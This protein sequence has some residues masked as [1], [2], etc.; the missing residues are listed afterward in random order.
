MSRSLLFASFL[1]A[2][3]VPLDVAAQQQFP[4]TLAGH[5]VL[6]AHAALR[7]KLQ[8]SVRI[9]LGDACLAGP[10]ITHVKYLF[11]DDDADHILRWLA[12]RKQQPEVKINHGLLLGSE[13]GPRSSLATK[14]AAT[15]MWRPSS[16][17]STF[18]ALIP[19][20]RHRR[21]PH[22]GKPGWPLLPRLSRAWRG[23]VAKDR[24]V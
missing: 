11:S 5:A 4:A 1:V 10:W 22:S 18:P 16:I 14:T 3:A 7:G 2:L 24:R 23:S 20:R 15:S 21:P 13:D 17:H 9:E 12:Q 8:E 6:P 19:K